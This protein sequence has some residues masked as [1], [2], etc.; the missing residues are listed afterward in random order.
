MKDTLTLF[1]R[2]KQAVVLGFSEEIISSDGGII[3]SEKIEK[4]SNLI[5]DFCNCLTD[6]RHL[7]YVKHPLFN[8]VKQRVFLLNQGYEDAND[9]KHLR[10][11]PVLEVVLNK[12]SV[13]QPT[14]SR[15]ENSIRNRY[16]YALSE[17]FAE[18]YIK[19][20]PLNQKTIT[21]DVDSTDAETHGSQQYSMFNGYYKHR[22]YH[23]L[24]FHDGDTG[25]LILPVLRPGNVHTA[26]DFVP[27]LK[28]LIKK[29]KSQR[30]D[31][32]ILIRA[33]SGF[34]GEKFYSL[35]EQENLKFCI[36]IPSNQVLQRAVKDEEDMIRNFFYNYGEKYQYFSERIEY[37]AESWEFPQNCYAKIESTSKGMNTRFIC[38]NMHGKSAKE[39]YKDY[40]VKRGDRSENRIKEIKT[41]CYSGRLSC[42]DFTANYFRL[43]LSALSY[44]MFRLIKEKIRKTGDEKASKWQVSNIRLFLLKVGTRVVKKA[45]KITIEFSKAYV[46]RD[47]LVQMLI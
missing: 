32:K 37:K 41:M 6:M 35:V 1:Y 36:G 5:R 16:L 2:H 23:P 19:S 44:E 43:M 27:I 40:Y 39:L 12:E 28:R 33:D 20:I 4:E 8:I 24:Y 34:S 17:Y 13:S 14:I 29:I 15:L 46:C 25:Q 31:I 45:R 3:L 10:Y 22:V 47:L 11:D 38:T 18:R 26:K 9:E 7:S 42:H 30:P 21:I